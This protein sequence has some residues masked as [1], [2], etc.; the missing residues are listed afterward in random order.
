MFHDGGCYMGEMHG[1]W[2]IFW[3]ILLVVFLF[4][5]RGRTR[6]SAAPLLEAPHELLRRRLASGHLNPGK[7]EE[8]KLLLV[9]DAGRPD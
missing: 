1:L 5:G 8:R 4:M 9:R 6:L 2:W 3:L 7:Y